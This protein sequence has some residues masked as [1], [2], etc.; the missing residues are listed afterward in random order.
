MQRIVSGSRVRGALTGEWYTV[1]VSANLDYDECSKQV[2]LT[3]GM[4]R[5]DGDIRSVVCSKHDPLLVTHTE[6]Q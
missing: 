6:V 5:R 2:A 3:S 4:V 1:T